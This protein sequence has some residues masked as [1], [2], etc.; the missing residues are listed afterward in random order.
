MWGGGTYV[1]LDNPDKISEYV[2]HMLGFTSQLLTFE[3][4]YVGD[5]PVVRVCKTN[6][7]KEA[8]FTS[9]N[10]WSDDTIW[11]LKLTKRCSK[12]VVVGNIW[13]L[14]LLNN[15][16]KTRKFRPNCPNEFHYRV[17][18]EYDLVKKIWPM[19]MKGIWIRIWGDTSILFRTYLEN[20][21]NSSGCKEKLKTYHDCIND[22]V[23]REM[24]SNITFNN[25]SRILHRQFK[26][27]MKLSMLLNM[28]RL[29][30]YLWK[31]MITR[32]P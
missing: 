2:N 13:Y 25:D 21:G 20:T 24:L 7:V 1:L 6:L 17:K 18:Q 16:S 8:L 27:M 4:G 5:G 30:Y 31:V 12:I 22:A 14:Y 19:C 32:N 10:C 28:D 26:R 11:N 3:D 15:S 23:Y 29:S 9:E